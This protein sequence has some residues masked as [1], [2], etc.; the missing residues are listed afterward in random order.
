M[1]EPEIQIGRIYSDAARPHRAW[2]VVERRGDRFMLQRL[3]NPNIMRFEDAKTLTD[4]HQ[5][6]RPPPHRP[7]VVRSDPGAAAAPDLETALRDLIGR[8]EFARDLIAGAD[9]PG[10]RAILLDLLGTADA[11]LALDAH[12]SGRPAAGDHDDGEQT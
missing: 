8:V 11:R 10:D 2:R 9:G 1:G 4:T 12:R 5:Y 3:D 6:V 7:A